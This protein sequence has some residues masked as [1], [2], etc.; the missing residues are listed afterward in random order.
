MSAYFV[1]YLNVT[2]PDRFAE[3]FQVVMPVIKRRGGR[4]IAQGTPEVIEGTLSFKQAVL[5]EWRSRQDLLEYW[6]SDEYAQIKKLREGAAEFQ[7][8]VIESI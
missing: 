1:V 3:Y 7:A 6:H 5:F 8:V 2:E 4:L